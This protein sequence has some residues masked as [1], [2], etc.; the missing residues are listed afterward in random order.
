MS[1]NNND[2][3]QNEKIVKKGYLSK[4]SKYL[5]N[6]KKRYIVL[7]ENY[8]F[9][10]VDHHPNSEC[11]MNLTISDCYG[12]KHLQLENN[13][14]YGFSFSNEGNIYCFKSDNQEEVNS[15]FDTLRESLSH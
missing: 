14:E 2:I 13:N 7:T 8:I 1:N 10:Y 12:P 11:T 6:W 15:W 3:Y 5:G 9:A 4:K